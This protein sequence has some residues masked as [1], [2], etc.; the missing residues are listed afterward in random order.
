MKHEHKSFI[1]FI[2]FFFT[3]FN[4]SNKHLMVA[5]PAFLTSNPSPVRLL[6]GT[7]LVQGLE[8]PLTPTL[9]TL[10]SILLRRVSPS[11]NSRVKQCLSKQLRLLNKG[12]KEQF[13]FQV[14]LCF[15]FPIA[16]VFLMED[17]VN[18]AQDCKKAG[19][20]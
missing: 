10:L 18:F 2:Y 15:Y 6:C 3:S 8:I 17:N 16:Y 12:C 20:F 5:N 19:L 7:C 13:L 4:F 1:M 9:Q 11:T 14:S